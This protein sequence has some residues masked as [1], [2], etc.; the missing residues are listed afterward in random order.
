MIEVLVKTLIPI[1]LGI[2]FLSKQ[3]PAAYIILSVSFILILYSIVNRKFDCIKYS[4]VGSLSF[5]VL[6]LIFG[7]FQGITLSSFLDQYIFYPQTIA[8]ERFKNLSLTYQN[9]V[10]KFNL[11]YLVII[12]LLYENLKKIFSTKNYIKH[13][14]FYVFL[15]YFF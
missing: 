2:A 11:I 9:I 14:N 8:A 1:F 4:F 7:K 10:G 5:V 3:V 6:I 13:D 15:T 12:P